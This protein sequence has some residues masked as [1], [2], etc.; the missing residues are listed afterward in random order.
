MEVVAPEDTRLQYCLLVQDRP[1]PS[2]ILCSRRVIRSSSLFLDLVELVED[3]GPIPVP[4]FITRQIMLDLVEMVERGDWECAHLVLVSLSYLLDFLIAVDFLGCETI[5]HQVEEKIKEKLCDSNWR[6]VFHYTQ[7]I[8]GL[9]ATTR[10]ALEFL[11]SRISLLSK[12]GELELDCDP[13]R[14]EYTQF[15]PGLLKLMLRVEVQGCGVSLKFQILHNWVMKQGLQD[16]EGEADR[17]A[18]LLE[19]LAT[20]KY[21]LLDDKK[22]QEVSQRVRNYWDL[23]KSELLQFTNMLELAKK[24]REEESDMKKSLIERKQSLLL[25]RHRRDH[26]FHFNLDMMF[27]IAG[28]PEVFLD[29]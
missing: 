4:S 11:L 13:Y 25:R 7:H 17:G 20:L 9:D 2:P 24:E 19:L 18:V 5:K 6:D 26:H 10:H 27:E 28:G 23:D 29:M 1:S 15:P 21:K 8:I 16:E 22:L 14:A 12:D 3:P